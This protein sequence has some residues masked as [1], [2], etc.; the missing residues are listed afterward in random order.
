MKD[1]NSFTRVSNS[2]WDSGWT[3]RWYNH[4]RT[5]SN[6]NWPLGVRTATKGFALIFSPTRFRKRQAP[7]ALDLIY[8]WMHSPMSKND[9]ILIKFRLN[10]CPARSASSVRWFSNKVVPENILQQAR[11]S[12]CGSHPYLAVNHRYHELREQI[13]FLLDVHGPGRTGL[14]RNEKPWVHRICP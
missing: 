11:S 8:L 3:V 14:Q 9:H 7:I 2:S 10:L 13:V 12:E 1:F 4:L 5:T 6:S